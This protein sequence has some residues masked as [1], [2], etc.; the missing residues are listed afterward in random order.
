ME[1]TVYLLFVG[2]M[3]DEIGEERTIEILKECMEELSDTTT[4]R[5]IDYNDQI[6]LSAQ[7]WLDSIAF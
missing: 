3:F 2:K 6:N 5:D 4:K 1:K 7:D